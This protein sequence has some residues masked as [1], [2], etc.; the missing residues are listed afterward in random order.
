VSR[1]IIGRAFSPLIS[2]CRGHG[3]SPYGG[4]FRAFSPL[5]RPLNLVVVAVVDGALAAFGGGTV[6]VVCP[7]DGVVDGDGAGVIAVS[8]KLVG[9]GEHALDLRGQK[10]DAGG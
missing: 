10:G 6:V 8:G 4:I 1:R 5:D 3:A 7:E 2:W 9:S